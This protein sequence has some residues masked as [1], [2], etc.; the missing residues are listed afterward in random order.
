MFKIAVADFKEIC[1][2][3]D[4]SYHISNNN[5]YI[6]INFPITLQESTF[7]VYQVTTMPIALDSNKSTGLS[8][9]TN[10]ASYLAINTDRS[11]YLELSSTDLLHCQG[12]TMRLCLKPFVFVHSDTVTCTLALF[13]SDQHSIKELHIWFN[14]ITP[15]RT[16]STI[17]LGWLLLYRISLRIILPWA[18]WRETTK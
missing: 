12:D 18:M 14:Q 17:Y 2:L 8:Q 13:R 4:I 10:I 7:D 5:I 9:I 6:T 3:I 16:P 1:A 15:G 11:Y